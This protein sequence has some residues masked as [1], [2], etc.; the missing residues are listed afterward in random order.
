MWLYVGS[1]CSSIQFCLFHFQKDLDPK[2][3]VKR[4]L[5]GKSPSK[6]LRLKEWNL[7]NPHKVLLHPFLVEKDFP[8]SEILQL[9]WISLLWNWHIPGFKFV[10]L[11]CLLCQTSTLPNIES[12]SGLCTYIFPF[13]S[14]L[15][16]MHISAEIINKIQVDILIVI[17]K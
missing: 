13:P 14:L 16:C 6:G 12:M 17:P 8:Y 10:F 11:I 7:G 2:S 5:L 1:M 3:I 4:P 9:Y 15:L